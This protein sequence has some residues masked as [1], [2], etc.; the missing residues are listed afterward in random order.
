MV[1]VGAG[2]SMLF[3]PLTGIALRRVTPDVAGA[4]SGLLGTVLSAGLAR[5]SAAAGLLLN[6]WAATEHSAEA[7]LTLLL[8]PLLALLVAA[9]ASAGS[10][11]A[12]D[13]PRGRRDSEILTGR[14]GTASSIGPGAAAWRARWPPW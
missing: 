11:S 4:A 1:V 2:N 8:L 7:V 10:A 14:P 12:A 9:L 13:H 6:G 3:T 5:G